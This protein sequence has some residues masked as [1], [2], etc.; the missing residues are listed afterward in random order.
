VQWT[1]VL[2]DRPEIEPSEE[3]IA[4]LDMRF[5][6][7]FTHVTFGKFLFLVRSSLDSTF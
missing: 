6:E 2:S 7:Q 4:G 3:F 5:I 1:S